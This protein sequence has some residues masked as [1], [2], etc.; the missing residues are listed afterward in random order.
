[1]D[2]RAS[3]PLHLVLIG[4]NRPASMARL[5]ASLRDADYGPTRPAAL[6]VSV[7]LDFSGNSTIDAAIDEL[8]ASLTS[9]WPH[10]GVRVHRRR[11]RAGLRDNVLGA[12][13]PKP[14]DPPALFLEDDVELSPLWWHW[15]QACLRRYASPPPRALLGISLYTP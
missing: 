1:M 6:S 4:W 8:V 13:H 9:T 7:A 3:R 5:V 15:V 11:E 10:G 14:G 2:D 12:W